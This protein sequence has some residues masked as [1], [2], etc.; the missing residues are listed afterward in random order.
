MARA[1]ILAA[2]G[3]ETARLLLMSTSPSVSARTR[4]FEW[5]RWT[6][7]HV[8]LLLEQPL[9]ASSIRSTNTRAP[10]S[11]ASSHDFY[12]ADPKRGFYGGGGI[13]ARFPYNPIGFAMQHVF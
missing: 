2:N 8:Q 4:E 10:S 11:V 9:V 6:L 1:T 13:D 3:A 12:E 5:Q 7:S